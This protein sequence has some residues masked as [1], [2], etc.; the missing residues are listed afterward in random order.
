MF[1][2]IKKAT[3]LATDSKKQHLARS[4]PKLLLDLL[5]DAEN[6]GNE[7]IVSWTPDGLAFKVHERDVF[8]KQILPNY[9]GLTKYN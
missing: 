8:M 9:F 4:F 3:P 5:E 7:H 2:E 6:D 1:T